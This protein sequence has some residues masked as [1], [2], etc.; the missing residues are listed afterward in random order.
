MNSHLDTQLKKLIAEG[1][2][3]E[4]IGQLRLALE[5][6]PRISPTVKSLLDEMT[7]VSSNYEAAERHYLQ[8]KINTEDFQQAWAKTTAACL[9]II[10]RLPEPLQKDVQPVKKQLDMAAHATDVRN[11]AKAMGDRN[12]IVQDIKNGNVNIHQSNGIRLRHVLYLLAIV[13]ALLIILGIIW[14]A[15][16]G[17]ESYQY[18]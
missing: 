6:N 17:S 5:N 2:L 15:Y 13:V 7:L 16:K 4:A 11:L 12:I 9:D 14:Q 18:E 8:G 1:Y 3:R 10:N